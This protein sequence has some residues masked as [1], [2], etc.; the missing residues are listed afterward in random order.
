[1]PDRRRIDFETRPTESAEAVIAAA[2]RWADLSSLVNLDPQRL[3]RTASDLEGI[4]PGRRGPLH[5][6][7]IAVKDNIDVVGFVTAAG[8]PAMPKRAPATDARV[9]RRLREADALIC[10]K[11]TMHELGLGVTSVNEW[12]GPVRNP[13]DPNL[14]AG[15]SSGGSAAAVAAGIVPLALGTDTGGSIRIPSA[16]CGT[17]GFRPTN[18]RWPLDG[19]VPVSFTRD[20][21]GPIAR[22]VAVCAL[23]DEVVCGPWRSQ[24]PRRDRIIVGV[25]PVLWADIDPEVHSSCA[26]VLDK[27]SGELLRLKEAELPIDLGHLLR[28]GLTIAQAE[29]LGS[30]E[31]YCQQAGHRFDAR[32][33][34]EQVRS[35][36]VREIL[37]DLAGGGGPEADAHAEA[38]RTRNTDRS[39]LADWFASRGID[40]LCFPTVAV[41]AVP[42]AH[43]HL[44]ELGGEVTSVFDAYTRQSALAS[45]LGLPAITIPTDRGTKQMPVGLE[46]VGRSG[47]DRILLDFAEQIEGLT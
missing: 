5:G 3:R 43:S 19:V 25:P 27:A 17:V 13:H 4:P 32:G 12:S 9:V 30:I 1:M 38:L 45:V 15:G 31:R 47:D 10:A 24:T 37:E 33:F 41:A 22:S 34:T 6:V 14:V 29:T 18:G 35:L 2:E 28:Y 16:L 39:V 8:S 21:V 20:T 7:P 11:T 42:V 46:L 36:D 44:T 40:F 23:A 26:A